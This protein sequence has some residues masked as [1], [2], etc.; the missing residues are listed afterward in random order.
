MLMFAK[1]IMF[2]DVLAMVTVAQLDVLDAGEKVGNMATSVL[3]GVLSVML[4]V[5]V[6]YLFTKI[7]ELIKIKDKRLE[8]VTAALANA[9]VLTTAH[10]NIMVE[11]KDSNNRLANALNSLEQHC[12]DV[13]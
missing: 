10:N 12:R 5:T 8:A 2:L 11:V 7:E 9:N 13:R 1:G 3:L 4:V 6:I